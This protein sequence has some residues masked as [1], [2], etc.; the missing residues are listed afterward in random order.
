M[1]INEIM[2]G[3]ADASFPGLLNLMRDYVAAV[4][5]K[6]RLAIENYLSFISKK[7]SGA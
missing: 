2:N 3:K 4:S 1:T 7:S 5:P 6:N